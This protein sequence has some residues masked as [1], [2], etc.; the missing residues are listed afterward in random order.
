[1]LATMRAVVLCLGLAGASQS[2]LAETAKEAAGA[3]E[4]LNIQRLTCAAVLRKGELKAE[5]GE[6]SAA[7]GYREFLKCRRQAESEAKAVYAKVS[8]KLKSS[9]TRSS[10]KDYHAALMS[11]LAAIGTKDGEGAGD[12]KRRMAAHDEKIEHAWQKLQLDL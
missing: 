5:M 11:A 7:D 8:A 2:A 4:V 1:M 9:A 3:Y 10:L 6:V 12:Y